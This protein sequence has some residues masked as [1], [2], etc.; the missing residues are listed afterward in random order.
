MSCRTA[1]GNDTPDKLWMFLM[2]K[3]HASGEVPKKRWELWLRRDS[4]NAK[5]LA[6]TTSKGYFIEN[7][8]NFDAAF[9]G[10]SPK[11]AELMDPHQRL[12][13]ELSWEALENAGIDPKRLAG[14]DTAVFMGVDSD[15]YSRLVMEDLPNVEACTAVDAACAS[16][17]IAIHLGRQAILS[18][19]STVAL[20]GG[21]NVLCAP[22][23]TYMLDK[24]GALASD[25]LCISFDD[26]AHGYARGEGGAIVVLKKLS[27][28]I[29]DNDNI[30]A[31]LKGTATAQDGK[32]NGIMAPNAKAQELVARQALSR[33]GDLDPLTIGYVEAH[34]TSTSLGDPTEIGAIAQ[35]YGIGRKG[36]KPCAIGSIKPN[37]GHLEAAAGAIG[38]VKA[39]LAV[40]KGE[41]AP[42]TLLKKLNTRVNW[43]QSG[44][45]VVQETSTWSE[46]SGPRR[47]AI[48]SY[49]Y[50]GSVAHAIIE[51]APALYSP[52]QQ[53]AKIDT[54]EES[55]NPI[56]LVLSSFQ[57]KR[58]AHQAA[59]AT[60]VV[61]TYDEAIEAL[62]KF[63]TGASSYWVTN[64]RV[65]GTVTRK[66]VVWVFSGHGAQWPSMAKELLGVAAFYHTINGLDKVI[67]EEAGFSAITALQTGDISSASKVQVLTYLIQIG[68][69]EV[70]RRKGIE[71]QAIV[72]HSV[73]EIAASVVAGCL[74]AEEGALLVSRRAKLYAQVEGQGM[75]ALVYLPF[76]RIEAELGTRKDVVAAINSSPSSCVVSGD[77]VSL[78]QYLKALTHR[79]VK[80]FPVKTDIAF[81]SPKL[82]KL[83]EPL[84]RA[85]NG[86]IRPRAATIPIYSTSHIDPRTDTL[87]D[88]DYW[89]HNMIQP[90][91]LTEAIGAAV[92]D[93][94][95]LFLEVST[96]P[97]VTHSIS[98]T[99]G[100]SGVDESATMGV[101][102]RDVSPRRSIMHAVSQLYTHGASVDFG[103]Q[104]GSTNWA[105]NVPGT[106]WVQKPYW[107]Q[108][109]IG[110]VGAVQQHDVDKHSLLGQ[111]FDVAGSDTHI[112]TTILEESIKPY[113]LSHSL[114]GTEII[115]AAVY[116]NTFHHAAGA[117]ILD[118]LQ[119]RVP[120]PMTADQREI[121]VVIQ[122]ESLRLS[123]RLKSSETPH[124]N[125]HYTWT[126][127]SSCRWR[128]EDMITYHNSYDIDEIKARTCTKLQTGFAWDF[129]QRLGVSGIA[130]PWAVLQHFRNDK[131]MIV[132]IDV[133]P[134]NDIVTWDPYSWA[135]LL[136]AA[137]SVGSSIFF[138]KPK[139]RIVSGIDQVQFVSMEAPPK[140]G[141]LYIMKMNDVK[142]LAADI[143]VLGEQGE[144]LVKLKSMRFS[145][146]E[147]ASD[148]TA[149]VDALVH[150]L[151]WV[152]PIFA[153]QPL[154]MD[155]V[156]LICSDEEISQA[157]SN[158]LQTCAKVLLRVP[159]V[160][161]FY[162]IT[163]NNLLE[164]SGTIVVYIPGCAQSLGKIPEKAHTFAWEATRALKHLATLE[165]T[166]K[167]F[168]ITDSIY[169]ASTPTALAQ[170]SLYGFAR[171][172]AQ[173]H[174]ELWGGLIDNENFQFPTLAVKYV[175]NQDVIR[176]QD[177]LPRIARMRPFNRSQQ[178]EVSS[179]NTLLP[180]AHGT[181]VVTGGF[182]DLGLEILDF[183]V[184]KGARRIVV[185]SRSGLPPRRKWS[186]VEGRTKTTIQTIQ[187]LE[188]RGAS[189]YSI[190]LDISALDA[191]LELSTA[192]ERLCLP[193]VLGVVHAAGINEDGLIKDTTSASFS[194]V[195]APKIAGVLTLHNLFPVRALDFF[196]LFSSIGQ[197]VG[198]SGQAPYGAANAFLDALAT[199]RRAQGD[200]A[201]AIQWTAWRDMGLAADSEFLTA[202]LNTKGITDITRE[203]GFQAWEYLDKYSTDHAV[204]TR[205]RMLDADEPIPFPLVSD[206][207]QRR[208]P[209]S[210]PSPSAPFPNTST[211][212]STPRKGPELKTWLS[213]KIR[214]CIGAVLH[215]DIEDIDARAAVADL[216]IDSVITVA[217]RWELTRVL[218]VKVPPTLMWK[219]PTVGHLVEWF[220]G[221]MAE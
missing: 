166:P 24:A 48:C 131:E 101:M 12:A 76:S 54:N 99:L 172:A 38:F 45:K 178:H 200:N 28:A 82:Q 141:Y 27:S 30:L 116:C 118:N 98:E 207:A 192:L 190:A 107:K 33:A 133:D 95:R 205:A 18:G 176:I 143:E 187:Q 31:V 103:T 120:T 86:A 126:E 119:L 21:V 208:R 147:V 136:D 66:D 112:F 148:R 36:D 188:H 9:F 59:Q 57:E 2:G 127:H 129:L 139:L 186:C 80:T 155:N 170:A 216:G 134:K 19:E 193:P 41:L 220:A 152:P 109:E 100:A 104:L 114:H 56:I 212:M 145:D 177:G 40:N 63:A 62:R 211:N 75:M 184:K 6:N 87:R 72:G 191:D 213:T 162:D 198:T 164:Q 68:L 209:P 180:K 81:H 32:T 132:K 201:I 73:G 78:K 79:G 105:T 125:S 173:E 23:L 144:L 167:L 88:V 74:S 53:T 35:V 46:D 83:A 10:V 34:A 20:C 111:R 174:P 13:L 29:A 138:S 91:W 218:G 117:T 85:L 121:Q 217:L 51:Q 158:N 11:E 182:G 194:R 169:K 206:I 151:A 47:A 156:L 142:G 113:P 183:L 157:Y 90:V 163:V 8:E 89:V 61:D 221:K 1:G 115:P 60:F 185:A 165:T 94:Y 130:Y 215:M 160:N 93:G 37:V 84:N 123:S 77:A 110:H 195:F 39:V 153:E 26:A 55:E 122:G 22:G 17:L 102:K 140:I 159:S 42:Q 179:K 149:G 65:F 16:S 14:S 44:L 204:V 137:T 7:L 171:I 3:K 150:Q 96:H 168:I 161:D 146:I 128:K 124:D 135:P 58:L 4:R 69:A 108:V 203:E 15:D 52:I 70:L 189:I 210:I 92:N 214:E 199:H 202:E 71:P 50:G 49:G 97:I 154:D 175:Q 25:G 219:E 5:I 197:L 43:D 67:E 106:P 196:I 181:Y 64:N